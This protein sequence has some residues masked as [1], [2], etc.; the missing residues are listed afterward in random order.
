[1]CN[2]L[3]SKGQTGHDKGKG[4]PR[5]AETGN[6]NWA[7]ER[8]K[9]LKLCFKEGKGITQTFAPAKPIFWIYSWEYIWQHRGK[10]GQDGW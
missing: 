7:S 2:S 4:S 3:Y 10:G 9:L 8:E 5:D 1:M 6:P